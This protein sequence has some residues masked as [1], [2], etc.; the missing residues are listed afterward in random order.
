MDAGHE[1][2]TCADA[3]ARGPN[4]ADGRWLVSSHLGNLLSA[5]AQGS[6]AD[7]ASLV[8]HLTPVQ[9]VTLWKFSASA[10]EPGAWQ[11]ISPETD[12]SL[13]V[14]GTSAFSLVQANGGNVHIV[15]TSDGSGSS[16]ISTISG[17]QY[18][19][20][21]GGTIQLGGR[22]CD[23]SC[24]SANECVHFPLPSPVLRDRPWCS[25]R[26]RL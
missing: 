7:M 6:E 2:F 4:Y 1:D 25:L 12:R 20:D 24:S 26:A 17:Q 14:S 3:C 21:L 8:S 15:T 11:I 19:G 9:N 18:L 16:T 10:F 13:A 23:D 22:G 5:T